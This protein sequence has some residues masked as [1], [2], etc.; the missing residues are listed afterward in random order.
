MATAG[1]MIDNNKGTFI[2]K[3]DCLLLLLFKELCCLGSVN[4][5]VTPFPIR[6]TNL[7]NLINPPNR[8]H[9]PQRLV[10]RP[11]DPQIIDTVVTDRAGGIEEDL[12]AEGDCARGIEDPVGAGYF[13]AEI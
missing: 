9:Q 11:P 13:F 4:G 10:H 7:A 12:A 8:L 3:K 2:N 6:R 1:W 5:P